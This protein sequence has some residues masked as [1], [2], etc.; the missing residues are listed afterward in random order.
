MITGLRW[1][2]SYDAKAM[3]AVGLFLFFSPM[4]GPIVQNDKLQPE[5]VRPKHHFEKPLKQPKQ[6]QRIPIEIEKKFHD[7]DSLA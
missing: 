3:C 5:M 6:P 1:A 4:A 7:L 2:H